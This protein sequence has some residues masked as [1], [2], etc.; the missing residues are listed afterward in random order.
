MIRAT[1]EDHMLWT[2]YG[3]AKFYMANPFVYTTESCDERLINLKY[4]SLL[5]AV[6][7]KYTE[8][9]DK[10][11]FRGRKDC[12]KRRLSEVTISDL[13]ITSDTTFSDYYT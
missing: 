12:Y 2:V 1:T 6:C 10:C 7:E 3:I 8:T 11:P 13:N 5:T 9:H 4:A